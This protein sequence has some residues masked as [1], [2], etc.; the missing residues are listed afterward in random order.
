VIFPHGEESS[1]SK[2]RCFFE[3]HMQNCSERVLEKCLSITSCLS[4]DWT[5][6][7]A[8][9]HWLARAH[10]HSLS[11][12]SEMRSCCVM[13]PW[14][15]PV[16]FQKQLDASNQRHDRTSS[17]ESRDEEHVPVHDRTVQPLPTYGSLPNEW[18]LRWCT[19]YITPR[20]GSR[21]TQQSSMAGNNGA[22]VFSS[23]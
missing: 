13:Q 14:F 16:A 8:G 22:L 18:N 7:K 15:T 17:C 21:G 9:M 19:A 23:I 4:W 2:T 10:E 20:H 5:H 1:Q 3:I 11:S 12:T 6:E